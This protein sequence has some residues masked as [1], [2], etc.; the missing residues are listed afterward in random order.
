[1]PPG[2]GFKQGQACPNAFSHHENGVTTSVHG[3]DFTSYGP[4]DALEWLEK[5]IGEAYDI[6]IGPRLGPGPKDGRE[7]R[8]LN[9]TIRW[10]DDHIEYEADLA[11]W[12]NLLWS[13]AC[14]GTTQW[15]P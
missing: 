5:S 9:R 2:L 10:C 7:T 11:R 15:Q 14:R 8:A 3:D 1:M 13:A 4:K 12:R 6:T